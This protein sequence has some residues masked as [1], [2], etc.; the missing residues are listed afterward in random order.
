MQHRASTLRRRTEWS[1]K[2]LWAFAEPWFYFSQANH[3]VCFC[4]KNSTS[5]RLTSLPGLSRSL[6]F[7]Q[8]ALLNRQRQNGGR[9]LLYNISILAFFLRKDVASIF[10]LRISYVS[11][12]IFMFVAWKG[13]TLSQGSLEFSLPRLLC[14][15]AERKWRTE[16]C[17]LVF[18]MFLSKFKV[19]TWH[20]IFYTYPTFSFF[21][22]CLLLGKQC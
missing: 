2:C 5:L 11:W 12:L 16:T 10:S 6:F 1:H 17:V 3:H 8:T 7:T 18:H 21:G 19:R 20:S 9:L 13:R 15:T 14:S 22:W 4:W